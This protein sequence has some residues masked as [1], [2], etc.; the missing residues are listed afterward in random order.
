[1]SLKPGIGRTWLEKYWTDVFPHGKVVVN[2]KEWKSPRYY[3]RVFADVDPDAAAILAFDRSRVARDYCED[4]SDVRL[5]VREV[6]ALARVR[7]MKRKI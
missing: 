7:S 3:D 4:N 5:A 2:G 6:V 1:M